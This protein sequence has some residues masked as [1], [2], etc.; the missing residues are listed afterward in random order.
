MNERTGVT[1]EKQVKAF[2]QVMKGSK[3]LSKQEKR[4]IRDK[5][6]AKRS[7]KKYLIDYTGD[8]I[9]KELSFEVAITKTHKN[10]LI[11]RYRILEGFIGLSNWT[12]TE[13]LH[14]LF[15]MQ[16]QRRRTPPVIKFVKIAQSYQAIC[17][18]VKRK[19]TAYR[20]QTEAE[21]DF[22]KDLRCYT[23]KTIESSFVI[24]SRVVDHY[25]PSLALAIENDGL[26]HNH[27]RKM[28][29]DELLVEVL[30]DLGVRV[31]SV[32]NFDSREK[33]I[34]NFKDKINTIPV[35]NS[36][37]RKQV[38]LRIYLL[39]IC[40]WSNEELKKYFGVTHRDL[41]SF[42]LK[43]I[44]TSTPRLVAREVDDKTHLPV[45]HW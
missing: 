20:F 2:K 19:N 21:M 10:L 25:I 13:R 35:H 44:K 45:I 34:L 6:K 32:D 8:K 30:G 43:Y 31:M 16:S 38:L 4:E 3:K 40:C 37:K 14:C 36:L 22:V 27:E 17:I 33:T 28:A 11:N 5:R 24:G 1:L 29:K 12:I 26:V 42:H 9:D 41:D 23:R 18:E 15:Y 39:T 7:E